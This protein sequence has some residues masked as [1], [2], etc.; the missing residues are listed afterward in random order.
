MLYL[1][2]LYLVPVLLVVLV[3]AVIVGWRLL[4]HR[5]WPRLLEVVTVVLLLVAVLGLLIFR[6]DLFGGAAIAA[7]I[8]LGF[9]NLR[10]LGR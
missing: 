1:D 10:D 8:G 5:P 9:L 7:A 4:K 3:G 6:F 2:P